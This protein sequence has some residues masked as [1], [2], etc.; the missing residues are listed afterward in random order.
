MTLSEGPLEGKTRK[1]DRNK[2]EV[3]EKHWEESCLFVS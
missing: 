3:V 1:R 2:G